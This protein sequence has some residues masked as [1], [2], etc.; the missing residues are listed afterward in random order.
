MSNV[1]EKKACPSMKE[2]R[3]IGVF[4][5]QIEFLTK[6]APCWGLHWLTLIIASWHIWHEQNKR[7]KI[8]KTH[9]TNLVFHVALVDM[10]LSYKEKKSKVG[11]R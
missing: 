3:S 10:E 4:M 11:H 9:L 2:P 6:K 1:L 7:W 5:E 8:G